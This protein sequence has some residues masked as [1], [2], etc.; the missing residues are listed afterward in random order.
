MPLLHEEHSLQVLQNKFLIFVLVQKFIDYIFKLFT[1]QTFLLSPGHLLLHKHLMMSVLIP[2]LR[3]TYGLFS[4]IHGYRVDYDIFKLPSGVFFNPTLGLI[5]FQLLLFS[6]SVMSNSLWPMDC[7]MSG[8]LV[9]CS[10]LEFAQTH[11]HWAD[12]A[13]QP[14]HPLSPASPLSLSPS[15]HQCLF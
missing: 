4:V 11:V 12:N 3:R 15:Q 1:I 5:H 8:F 7:S 2:L 14:S 10:L 13:I 9:L 6:C